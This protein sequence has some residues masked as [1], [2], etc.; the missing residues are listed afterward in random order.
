MSDG[1]R[2]RRPANLRP[3]GYENFQGLDVSQDIRAQDTGK[4]Q[5][6]RVLE[7]AYATNRG[8]IASEPGYNVIR[9][10]GYVSHLRYHQPDR[11]VWFIRRG[12]GTHL[13]TS[14]G[15]E[16]EGVFTS[17]ANI[18]STVFSR[19]VVAVAHQEGAIAYDGSNLDRLPL[20]ALN[21]ER[22]RPAY[23]TAV[24]RR[25][26]V[27]GIPLRETEVH[28]SRVDSTDVFP[29]NEDEA[30]ENVLRAA[31]IDI[32]NLIASGETIVG[33]APF[34][35]DRLAIFTQDR[36]LL[37]KVDPDLDKI[38]IDQGAN[39]NIGTISH[40]TIV[41]AGTDLLFCSRTGVHSAQRSRDNGILVFSTTLSDDVKDLYLQLV[42][43][44]EDPK[45]ISAVWDKDQAKYHIFFP[46]AGSSYSRRLT[47][48]MNPRADRANPTWSTGT[49]LNETC[50]D[51]LGG[52]LALGS[53]DGLYT[54]AP[55]L[56]R[57]ADTY[58]PFKIQTPFLWH[59]SLTEPKDTA[60]LLVQAS[61]YAN[62]TIIA[63]DQDNQVFWSETLQVEDDP[64]DNILPN[65]PL[66]HHYELK[67][68][69]RYKAV[70]FLIQGEAKGDFRLTGLAVYMR[71]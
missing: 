48:S 10:S 63:T 38:A 57:I 28:L 67:F 32:A 64:D 49:F 40:K 59:G 27:A 31:K 23:I 13:A 70:R 11:L 36:M 41:S 62:I 69:A 9:N 55:I 18:N 47:L 43:S 5:V 42:A 44:V 8:H 45:L 4:G 58:A 51:F 37:Y 15:N 34:E 65:Q 25:L 71:T 1:I 66:S 56:S 14:T 16:V 35:Q 22:M 30:S 3:V 20:S 6:L 26:I 33:I 60:R 29:D 21:T 7:N 52:Q 50:G 17:R 2:T 19:K 54:Q 12:D 39:V 61:G 46:Q 68:E 53:V 24:Q